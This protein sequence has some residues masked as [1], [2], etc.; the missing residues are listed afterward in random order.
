MSWTAVRVV[1]SA[2]RDGVVAALFAAGAQA[3]HDDG[4]AVV[5]HFPP[6]ADLVEMRSAVRR[7]DAGATIDAAAIPEVD[8]S[9]AWREGLTTHEAG[10]FTI[11]PPWLAPPGASPNT[12]VIDPG[13]AFG[14]GDHATTRG[15]LRLM[16]TVVRRGDRVADLGA[17]SGVLSIAA[18]RLG[19]SSVAAIELDA[20]AISNA[21]EN[22]TRNGVA[23]VVRVVEGDAAVLLPL[24]APVRVILANIIS[25]VLTR[26][27]AAMARALAPGGV[28]VLGG[29]LL[30]EREAM[31]AELEGRGWQV[32]AEDQ[33]DAWWSATV[34]RR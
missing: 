28:A 20:G 9:R 6:G 33:E 1:P 21:E 19:A 5:T 34:S 12:I 11:A 18:A 24:V 16:R 23:G 27:L 8:W 15:M 29:I 3:V 32:E 30:D 4:A 7:A 14:T 2:G 26:L 17:G 13:M 10:G 22:V 25:G 31:V